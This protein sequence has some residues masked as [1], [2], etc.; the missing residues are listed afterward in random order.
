[1]AEPVH[2]VIARNVEAIMEARR[3]HHGARTR[4]QRVA[5]RITT[6][7]GSV[8]SLFLHAAGFGGWVVANTAVIPGLEPWDPFPFPLLGTLAAVEA[9]FLTTF[10]LISQN[11]LVAIAEQRADLNLQI[12]LLTEQEV[13]R[14]LHLL[15]DVAEH[16]GVPRH[17]EVESM[18]QA[19]E[20]EAILAHLDDA[21]E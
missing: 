3:K 10:V 20:P 8:P 7:I 6:F 4:T 14:V 1:M 13:T 21:A 9:I 12:D 19:I 17:A 16:L 5:D 15:D 2:G 18:K 11:R